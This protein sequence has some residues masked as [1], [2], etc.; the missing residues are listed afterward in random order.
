VKVVA[1]E[2]CGVAARLG[3]ANAARITVWTPRLADGTHPPRPSR[4]LP[5]APVFAPIPADPVGDPV[6]FEADGARVLARV[7]FPAG[8]S[9]YGTGEAAGP[10]LRNGRTVTLWNSDPSPY[11]ETTPALYQSHPC[12]LAVLSDGRAVGLLADSSRRGT[13]RHASDAV[14]LA[15]EEEPFDLYWIEADHPLEATRGLAALVGTIAM[16]PLWALGYHQCRWSYM[17]SAELREVAAELRRRGIPC[18]ALWL[19]IDSMDRFQV[20]TFDRST[21]DDLPRL[22]DEL[23]DQGFR[24]VAILDPGLAVDSELA[25]TALERGLLVLDAEGKPAAGKVW[26][27]MCHFPD[28]TSA[29]VRAWWALEVAEWL[30]KTRFDGLWTDMNEPAVFE[31]PSR[32][33]GEDARHAGFDGRGGSHA[34][35]HNLYGQAMAWATREGFERAYPERRPFLLTRANH[36]CG[37]RFAATWTGDNR[38]RWEDL[39]WS[40]PMV[41]NL[42]LSA[43]P[44]A[45]PDVGGFQGD[46]SPE[47]FARWFAAAALLPFCRGHSEKHSCRKEPYAFGPEIEAAV[48]AALELRMRLLPLLYT[49]FREAHESGAPIARPLFFADPADPELRAADDAFLLGDSLLV[50][51]VVRAGARERKVR[52]PRVPGGWSAFPAGGERILERER[53]VPAPL[54]TL[55]LFARAGSILFECEPR[56]C[57]A[58]PLLGPL[59]VHVFPD[60]QGRAAGRLYEDEGE[61]HAHRDGV[62]RDARFSAR[63]DAGEL[64]IEESVTGRYESPFRSRC[65]IAH[66]AGKTVRM[67]SPLAGSYRIA[68]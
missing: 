68:T 57:S 56:A 18:D 46:P 10:L 55:P 2:R 62:F 67:V 33:L 41:L 58:S 9:F 39:A 32:T 8:T 40:I 44:F 42:G 34:V 66:L 12:V 15:F 50:A 22:T 35:W 24:T 13:I 27:G 16:P 49:L 61:G 25:K 20:F 6:A 36:I 60:E 54:G 53:A 1:V 45:G 31:V 17:S 30:E 65:F 63:L 3:V 48:R 38:S 4:I 5:V 26:P 11:D 52:F 28:F 14:E 43:Q 21:F 23:R 29:K 51:P 64:V 59:A 37:A 19:D 7:A 47:L